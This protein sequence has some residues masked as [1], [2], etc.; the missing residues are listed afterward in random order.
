VAEDAPEEAAAPYRQRWLRPSVVDEP[1]VGWRTAPPDFVGVGAQRCGTSWWYQTAL[2][3]H[4][5]FVQSFRPGKETHFF[6]QF[7][8]GGAPGDLA[9]RYARLFPRPEGAFAG[10]WTPDYMAHPWAMTLLAEAAP[11]ARILIMLRDPLERYASG[12]GRELRLADESGTPL[13]IGVLGDQLHRSLYARQVG[14]AF[15]LFGRERVLVLQY[16]RCR[17]EPLDEMQRM[18][19]FLGVEPLAELPRRAHRE[20]RHRNPTVALPERY[21]DDLR[22]WLAE[23]VATLARLCPEVDLELWPNFAASGSPA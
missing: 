7:W 1:P 3:R 21:R 8:R 10:E 11:E 9:E 12:I 22:A 17:A 14:R 2:K 20:P 6:D 4:P 15:E 18:H 16:E 5:A 13:H 23:D 19:R